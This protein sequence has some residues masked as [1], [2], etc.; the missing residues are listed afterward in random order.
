MFLFFVEI[1]LTP[2]SPYERNHGRQFFKTAWEWSSWSLIWEQDGTNV[3]FIAHMQVHLLFSVIS[4]IVLPTLLLLSSAVFL[5]VPTMVASWRGQVEKGTRNFGYKGTSPIIPSMLQLPFYQLPAK[6]CMFW[7]THFHPSHGLFSWL[8][9]HSTVLVM[10]FFGTYFEQFSLSSSDV[11][12][13]K[14]VAET[15]PLRLW[16]TIICLSPRID[17]ISTCAWAGMG[18]NNTDSQTQRTHR[19]QR[20]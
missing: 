14:R 13:T 17:N 11:N 16:D 7:V 12:K 20:I 10:Y 18:Q 1:L 4:V 9:N 5:K 2:A 19:T 3:S 8:R 15:A 6:V